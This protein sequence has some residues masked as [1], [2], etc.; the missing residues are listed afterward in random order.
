M[1][2]PNMIGDR[3][4]VNMRDRTTHL[5]RSVLLKRLWKYLGRQRLLIIV[6]ILLSSASS[7]LGLYGPKLSGIALNAIDLKNGSVDMDTVVHCVWLMALC[8]ILSA[9][10]TYFAMWCSS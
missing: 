4:A 7:V 8:Y 3:H 9:G 5:P 1:R 6:A 2:N 10:L